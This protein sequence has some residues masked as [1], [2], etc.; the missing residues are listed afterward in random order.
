MVDPFGAIG[1]AASAT[2]GFLGDALLGPDG[3]GSLNPLDALGQSL[4]SAAMFGKV[5]DSLDISTLFTGRDVFGGQNISTL[6]RSLGFGTLAGILGGGAI[7]AGITRGGP[8]PGG[9]GYS[10]AQT[11]I[12]SSRRL[13]PTGLEIDSDPTGTLAAVYG[14][15][16]ATALQRQT[17]RDAGGSPTGQRWA[18]QKSWLDAMDAE[19][20]AEALAFTSGPLTNR[21]LTIPN[22]PYLAEP[23]I[24]GILL[25]DGASPEA[26]E[27]M[28]GFQAG[29]QER[30][31][32]L[33]SHTDQMLQLAPGEQDL[34]RRAVVAYEFARFESLIDRKMGNS[35]MFKGKKA[36]ELRSQWLA[37]KAGDSMS[38][39]AMGNLSDHM[40]KFSGAVEGIDHPELRLANPL[41]YIS[42]YDMDTGTISIGQ[43]RWDSKPLSNLGPEEMM[44]RIVA[45]ARAHPAQLI[46][47]MS[48]NLEEIFDDYV[49]PAAVMKYRNWYQ[50][51]GRKIVAVADRR[52]LNARMLTQVA[53]ILSPGE[54]WETNI[55]KAAD[56]VEAILGGPRSLDRIHE[57]LIADGMTVSRD[58]TVKV[59]LALEH[60][61]PETMWSTGFVT[62]DNQ[63][64]ALEV[65][66][67]IGWDVIER[68]TDGIPH[69]KTKKPMPG[70]TR[71][72]FIAKKGFTLAE[73]GRLYDAGY[74]PKELI[75]ARR[76]SGPSMAQKTIA[77]DQGLTFSS[78]A[79]LEIQRESFENMLFGI[80]GLEDARYQVPLVA[81][82]QSFK[83][84]IGFSMN[85]GTQLDGVVYDQVAQAHRLAAIRLSQKH[86]IDI[87]PEELQATLWSVWRHLSGGD[88]SPLYP[89]LDRFDDGYVQPGARWPRTEQNAI[90]PA[91][92]VKGKGPQV[93]TNDRM[94]RVFSQHSMNNGIP[95][96]GKIASIPT[97]MRAVSVKDYAKMREYYG[98]DGRKFAGGTK[99]VRQT[100]GLRL[101]TNPDGTTS[102][103]GREGDVIDPAEVRGVYPTNFRTE[104]GDQV[105]F[106]RRPDRVLSTSALFEEIKDGSRFAEDPFMQ[107]TAGARAYN[108]VPRSAYFAGQPGWYMRV[109]PLKK[110]AN[111]RSD[112]YASKQFEAAMSREGIKFTA[113]GGE[114]EVH[115]GLSFAYYRPED[116]PEGSSP[117]INRA[118]LDAMDREKKLHWSPPDGV[119]QAE[120]RGWAVAPVPEIR[121]DYWYEFPTAADQRKVSVLLERLES[122]DKSR[123]R[124]IHSAKTRGEPIPELE[125]DA[126]FFPKAAHAVSEVSARWEG[127]FN[128]ERMTGPIDYE[129]FNARIVELADQIEAEGISIV[130]TNQTTDPYKSG[131]DAANDIEQNRQIRVA[132]SATVKPKLWS[133][134]LET[135]VTEDLRL[136]QILGDDI[137]V[138]VRPPGNTG[139]V[140]IGVTIGGNA[141]NP[142]FGDGGKWVNAQ[143]VGHLTWNQTTGRIEGIGV[144][145]K[146][147]RKGVAT[148][149]YAMAE[150]I[151]GEKGLAPVQ[152]STNLT[153]DGAAFVASMPKV[154]SIN[155]P[156]L[157]AVYAYYGRAGTRGVGPSL[158]PDHV[159]Y[160]H[161]ALQLDDNSLKAFETV[162]PMREEI[163]ETMMG[164]R[165]DDSPRV[166]DALFNEGIADR[167]F[168]GNGIEDAPPGTYPVYEHH[169]VDTDGKYMTMMSLDGDSSDPNTFVTHVPF[170]GGRKEMKSFLETDKTRLF[171]SGTGGHRVS[172]T[173]GG[174]L[175]W[176]QRTMLET[177]PG[178]TVTAPEGTVDRIFELEVGQPGANNRNPD[179]VWMFVNTQPGF[180]ATAAPT[181]VLMPTSNKKNVPPTP[182]GMVGIRIG[183]EKTYIPD[184]AGP[185]VLDIY[186]HEAKRLGVQANKI[187]DLK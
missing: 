61:N 42:G 83:T 26:T 92:W 1:D 23:Y 82:R 178:W 105:Y 104:S 159:A 48:L 155:K 62:R 70:A 124:A 169:Y 141:G 85:P 131:T 185:Y 146:Y 147:G 79:D 2:T 14:S 47:P 73:I 145:K 175:V 32:S 59:L 100:E 166:V 157:D 69:P 88:P 15:N 98:A 51:E 118:I 182:P 58:D 68:V 28:L 93:V 165:S 94:L 186:E 54:N 143:E 173:K 103:L 137:R 158:N 148:A 37:L 19:L 50:D 91:G 113:H 36:S 49:T 80:I 140:K 135:Y 187:E 60:T 107:G 78:N 130:F 12:E 87:L 108:T 156:L 65:A 177:S 111:G 46:E 106:P 132:G 151:A 136:T 77:F 22:D 114:T 6:E 4:Q 126:S 67:P 72:S 86:G 35:K 64:K 84:A 112:A 9:G 66:D 138:T 29:M 121:R 161:M 11:R 31:A 153:S 115:E 144:E 179:H 154:E 120:M 38:E 55:D 150:R 25:G 167:Q 183:K 24:A 122:T 172:S 96:E 119:T 45:S 181:L 5:G 21:L 3:E 139:N 162:F 17:I 7:Y 184:D 40:A 170:V 176:D 134:P 164:I 27:R 110:M 43:V 128:P 160:A 39:E 75:Y 101:E 16:N 152:H 8:P 10:Y 97:D 99:G 174:G 142:Q 90:T 20:D 117:P 123:R 89:G 56:T 163:L 149:L 74:D 95:I 76:L 33:K 133:G 102:I 63:A 116:L 13:G 180:E 18:P 129:S 52:G 53:A 171:D 30:Y 44:D 57:A 41:A 34:Y 71:E 127:R 125:T 109:A 168:F 81:D